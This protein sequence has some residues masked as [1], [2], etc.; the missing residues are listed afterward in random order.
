MPTPLCDADITLEKFPGKGGWTYALLPA[1]VAI[2][3]S[4]FNLVRV[5]GQI[6]DFPLE[7]V[8]LMALGKGRL[9]VAV[10]AAIRQR[11]GKQAGDTVRLVLFRAAEP[12]EAAPLTVSAAD[13][14]E[15]LAEVPG[16]LAAYRRLTAAQQYS[17]LAWVA[18]APSDDKKVQRADQACTMLA[19]WSS[20]APACLPPG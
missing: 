13:L 2:K 14:E 19:G 17:W 7:N 5:N 12:T 8:A 1:T 11:I 10:K 16:A 20:E 4:S 15:C 6:D 18:A 9:F 3:A